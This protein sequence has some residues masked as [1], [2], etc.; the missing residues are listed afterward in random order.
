MH[1]DQKLPPALLDQFALGRAR[2]HF[3]A[4]FRIDAHAQ[5][6][7]RVERLLHSANEGGIVGLLARLFERGLGLRIERMAEIIQR[8]NHALDLGPERLG[9][10]CESKCQLQFPESNSSN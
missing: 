6:A 7:K 8:F 1:L 5:E 4:R 2:R 3:H 10:E 9:G